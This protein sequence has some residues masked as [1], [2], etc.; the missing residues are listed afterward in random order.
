MKTL[1]LSVVLLSLS[2]IT[3]SQE[4]IVRHFN[5]NREEIKTDTLF[6]GDLVVMG[7]AKRGK[8][9]H[10]FQGKITGIFSDRQVVR[11]LIM[12]EVPGSC[13]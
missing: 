7:H 8:N 13:Q 2:T 11:F 3:Y 4:L 12:Q 1:C 6:L 5:A 9:P 10:Y